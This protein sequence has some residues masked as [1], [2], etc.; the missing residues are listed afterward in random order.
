MFGVLLYDIL[1][2]AIPIILIAFLGISIYRYVSAKKQ[3]KK[4]PG[5]FSPEEIEKRKMVLIALSVT[6][7]VPAAIIIGF[8]VLLSMA[9]AHM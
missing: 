1:F 9:V 4:A 3:N 5:T 6:A 7:G 2:F 8:M